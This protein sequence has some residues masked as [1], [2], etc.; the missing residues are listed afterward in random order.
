MNRTR[1]GD[2]GQEPKTRQWIA[3]LLAGAAL[4]A[5]D[6]ALGSWWTSRLLHTDDG[7]SA[8]AG[9]SAGVSPA[10]KAT[11]SA[12]GTSPKSLSSNMASLL[13]ELGIQAGSVRPGNQPTSGLLPALG[14]GGKGSSGLTG[15]IAGERLGAVGQLLDPSG[16]TQGASRQLVRTLDSAAGLALLAT[17]LLTVA[18]LATARRRQPIARHLAARISAIC[19]V[20]LVVV[21]PLA[22]LV[23]NHSHGA[24]ADAA[25]VIYRGGLPVRTTLCWCLAG[26]ASLWLAL[27]LVPRFGRRRAPEAELTAVQPFAGPRLEQAR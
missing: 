27:I 5:G 25:R 18:A 11:V 12:A 16:I 22:T 10:G 21:W 19:G 20:V 8:G 1:L 17:V 2:V 7:A 24:V 14:L 13:H 4:V 15:R 3:R 9:V 6:A 23:T 26:A